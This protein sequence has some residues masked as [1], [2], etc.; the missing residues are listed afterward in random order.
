M[1]D[2]G[3]ISI[4]LHVGHSPSIEK[5]QINILKDLERNYDI[6][7][8][9]RSERYPHAYKSYSLMMNHAIA[10]SKYEW[11]IFVN[12]RALITLKEAMRMI[13]HM[14]EGYAASFMYN[15]GYMMLSKQLIRTIGWWDERFIGGG[16]EDRDFVFRLKQHN[17]ALYESQ[18]SNYNYGEAKSPLQDINSKCRYSQ[19]H[20]DAKYDMQYSNLI[21]K[22]LPEEKYEHWDLFLREPREDI[23]Q[24]WKSWNDSQLNIGYN[25]PN[26]GP[27]A[28]SM[29]QNRPIHNL[30]EI[31]FAQ[32]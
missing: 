22:N 14:R 5:E 16:W 28:S 20:W 29:I 17:L 26:S 18:D 15:V 32:L 31:K 21:I 13:Q 2:I 10:T 25:R 9:L 27:S 3:E 11:M 1:I 8:N 12:D 4:N 24:S 30:S 23:K 19:P 7:W 6:D